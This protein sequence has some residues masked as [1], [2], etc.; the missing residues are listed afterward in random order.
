VDKCSCK[1]FSAVSVKGAAYVFI[2]SVIK[3]FHLYILSHRVIA[4]EW[5]VLACYTISY[6]RRN[7][8]SGQ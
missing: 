4:E 1:S 2:C 6:K 8:R 7:K 5:E 3:R